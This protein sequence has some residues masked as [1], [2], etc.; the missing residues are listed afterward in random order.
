MHRREQDRL[1]GGELTSAGP[2]TRSHDVQGMA[3]Y[4]PFRNGKETRPMR[5][6]GPRQ[7]IRTGN[8]VMGG[9]SQRRSRGE[10]RG[11]ASG[12]RGSGRAS[13]SVSS[14]SSQQ[15]QHHNDD[16]EDDDDEDDEDEE[17]GG[18]DQAGFVRDKR[19]EERMRSIDFFWT[20]RYVPQSGAE[21]LS[22]YPD[23][24]KTREKCEKEGLPENWRT[25][26]KVFLFFDSQFDDISNN[27]LRLLK[28]D[29]EWLN[30]ATILKNIVYEP[31]D[32]ARRHKAY[33]DTNVG[34]NFLTWMQ[35]CHQKFD[36]EFLFE[37]RD[38]SKE[39]PG[40]P[41]IFTR[42]RVGDVRSGVQIDKDDVIRMHIPRKVAKA[43]RATKEQVFG[44]IVAFEAISN[45]GLIDSDTDKYYGAATVLYIREPQVIPPL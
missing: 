44:K 19:Y 4:Y 30:N 14:S 16:E 10:G 42:L 8:H 18:D 39:S 22:F 9:P 35:L 20:N 17:S 1:L 15:R 25:R 28:V 12:S 13:A 23:D 29:E 40:G 37:K 38:K 45:D 11:S 24:I 7:R 21:K 3:F 36:Q 43:G 27:K 33:A 34:T 26:V 5:Y 2:S 6:T 41:A 31:K 32:I